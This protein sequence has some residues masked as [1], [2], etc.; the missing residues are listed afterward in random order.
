LS[1][2][3]ILWSKAVGAYSWPHNS[4]QLGVTFQFPRNFTDRECRL[5]PSPSGNSPLPF[6]PSLG[7]APAK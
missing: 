4:I 6:S 3:F 7:G 1:I 5:P 2:G